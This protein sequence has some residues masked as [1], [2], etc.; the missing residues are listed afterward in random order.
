MYKTH[1]IATVALILVGP[2]LLAGCGPQGDA[3]RNT[4][5]ETAPASPDPTVPVEVT[6]ISNQALDS[7][8]SDSMCSIDAV[9]SQ[10]AINDSFAMAP[11]KTMVFGGWAATTDKTNPGHIILV[12]K[13]AESFQ[14]PGS[15]GVQR[16]DVAKAFSS[17]G[18]MQS[19]FNA[20]VDTTPLPKGTYKLMVLEPS[21]NPSTLCDTH[22][23]LVLE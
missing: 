2:V 8:K 5:T 14:A 15:T 21:T 4:T 9:S 16:P 18:L 13:G 3:G 17:P 12:L 10:G 11:S 19:G 6:S 22:K 1:L 7:A 20:V 23:T